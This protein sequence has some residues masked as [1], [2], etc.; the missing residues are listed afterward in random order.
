MQRF[1]DMEN[2]S[3]VAFIA[4]VLAL[5]SQV[6]I[7]T[8]AGESAQRGLRMQTA[9]TYEGYLGELKTWE[10]KDFDAFW[11]HIPPDIF[12]PFFYATAI[13]F[14]LA[15]AM[16]KSKMSQSWNVLMWIPWVAGFLDEVENIAHICGLMAF[17]EPPYWTFLVG[18]PAAIIKWFLSVSMVMMILIILLIGKSKTTS[19]E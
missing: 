12:H 14:G 1:R 16:E 9:L 15:W 5:I 19:G 4:L 17:P 6:I 10:E 8:I 13:M 3:R 11:A 2:L 7:I 18:N